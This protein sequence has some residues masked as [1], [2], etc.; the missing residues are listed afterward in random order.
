M[1]IHSV[2]IK[3]S[4]PIL[5]LVVTLLVTIVLFSRLLGL[6]RDVIDAQSEMFLPAVSA[7]LN[8]DRDLY[9][10]RE[11]E[12][13]LMAGFGNAEEEESAR[14]ENAQQVRDRFGKYRTYLAQYPEVVDQFEGFD[15]A[16]RQWREAS[17]AMV[18]GKGSASANFEQLRQT[19]VERFSALRDILDSAGE[20]AESAAADM[21]NRVAG[22]IGHAREV[23]FIVVGVALLIALTISFLIP[24]KLSHQVKDLTRNIAR[25]AEGDGDLTA[26]IPVNSRDELGELAGEFNRFVEKLQVLITSIMQQ[27]S[28]FG[29]LVDNL[30]DAS[31]R[32]R[33]IT[34]S[35]DSASSAIVSAV[36]EM[37][38]ANKE[39]AGVANGTAAEAESSGALVQRGLDVVARTHKVISSLV[40]EMDR[41]RSS[42]EALE[43]ESREIA[44]VVDVI[45]GIAEQTNLLAL[46]AAIEAARAGEQGRGF[47]VVADE[48]RVL[49]TRTQES[50]GRIQGM[51]ERLETSVGE[52]V[53]V[54]DSSKRDADHSMETIS[55][56]DQLFA[57]LSDSFTRVSDLSIQTAHATEE[58]SAVSEEIGHNLTSLSEQTASATSISELNEQLAVEIRDLSQQISELVGRF[59]V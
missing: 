45:G 5:L 43:N 49:A 4:L 57:E 42:S 54:I 28:A 32:S 24:R 15:N 31:D 13:N 46:N 55:E 23:M 50:T 53:R 25:I 47:A 41:A 9:Q 14:V 51:I 30:T 17:D 38:M 35:L 29:R 1:S 58:Q 52:S 11:A 59:R 8:A 22:E 40:N 7:V 20:Q 48:V 56:L 3:S 36:H 2:R 21:R 44:S 12:L 39:M 19:E 27:S 10:A 33:S 37:S 18:A 26:R 34:V 6:Q 16:Y